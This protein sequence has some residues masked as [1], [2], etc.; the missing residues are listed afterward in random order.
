MLEVERTVVFVSMGA[1]IATY[2]TRLPKC[3]PRHCRDKGDVG[4]S[5]H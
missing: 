4:Q 2:W 3:L 5:V 1:L